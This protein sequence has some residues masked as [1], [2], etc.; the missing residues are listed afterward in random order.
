MIVVPSEPWKRTFSICNEEGQRTLM[1]EISADSTTLV[2][3]T[4]KGI[5]LELFRT[6]GMFSNFTVLIED[7][8]MK[9]FIIRSHTTFTTTAQILDTI[10]GCLVNNEVS[11]YW[12][13]SEAAALRC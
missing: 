9:Q 3:G 4:L 8:D 5:A 2:G 7:E 6:Q 12:D 1:L 13:S 10:H 11:H